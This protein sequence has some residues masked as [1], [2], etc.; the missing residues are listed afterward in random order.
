MALFT[1]TPSSAIARLLFR[2]FTTMQPKDTENRNENPDPEKSSLQLS[3]IAYTTNY[4]IS[5]KMLFS[6]WCGI[7][8]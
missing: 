7:A 4:T 3:I 2:E 8:T 5:R 1:I 6:G